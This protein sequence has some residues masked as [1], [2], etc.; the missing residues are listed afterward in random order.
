MMRICIKK[1]CLKP[2]RR[3]FR[4]CYHPDCG[5]LKGEEE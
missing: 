4:F 2:V 1:N 5:K 3:G